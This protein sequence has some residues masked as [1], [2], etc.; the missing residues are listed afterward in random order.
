MLHSA[1]SPSCAALPST[2]LLPRP[3]NLLKPCAPLF[4]QV[5]LFQILLD[6]N[7]DNKVSAEE[8]LH[9]AKDALA[10]LKGMQVGEWGGGVGGEARDPPLQADHWLSVCLSSSPCWPVGCYSKALLMRFCLRLW[11]EGGTLKVL[12]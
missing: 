10:M 9:A 12:C 2:P 3:G 11:Q 7:G 8:I 5:R 4:L 1:L 6:E